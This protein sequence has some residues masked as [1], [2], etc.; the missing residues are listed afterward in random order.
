MFGNFLRSIDSKGRLAFPPEIKKYITGKIYISYGSDNVLEVRTSESFKVWQE[1]LLQSN[2]L[3]KNL[4]TY[5]RIFFGSTFE[6]EC[7]K[8]GRVNIKQSSLD[9]ANIKKEIII[10]GLGDKLEIWSKEKYDE[11]QNEYSKDDA[12]DKLQNELNN[13]GVNL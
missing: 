9:F 2:S 12:I 6:T 1:K 7:D 5:K 3:N 11:F 13:E 4:K 8:L 10:L